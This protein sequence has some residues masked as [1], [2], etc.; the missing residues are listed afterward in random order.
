MITKEEYLEAKK[1][2]EYY[3]KQLHIAKVVHCKRLK[4]EQLVREQECGKHDYLSSR[5]KWSPSGRI[6]CQN[7]GKILD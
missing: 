3:T 7:C 5:G 1:T 2:V 4:E 6:S